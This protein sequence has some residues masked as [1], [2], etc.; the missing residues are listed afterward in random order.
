[1]QPIQGFDNIQAV[2]GRQGMLPGGPYV[3]VV[4]RAKEDVTGYGNPCLKVVYDIM[5][6]QFAGKFADIAADEDQDWRHTAEVDTAEAGGARLKALTDAIAA[7]NPGWV[8]DWNEAN[9]IGR[10]FGLVLQERKITVSKGK[11]K[12]K[13]RTYLDFWDAVPADAVRQGIVH[14]PPVN[15]Q[16][17]APQQPVTVPQGIAQQAAPVAAP[18]PQYAPQAAPMPPMAPTPPMQQPMAQPV[19]PQQ[20]MAQVPMSYQMPAQQPMPQQQADVYD[21]DIPF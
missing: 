5:E 4:V 17:D 2:H 12:G 19:A 14:T 3:A 13:N 18:N 6:G 9:M 1:M 7:S 8:W 21:H 11:N 20:P 16:R 15:D 10:V